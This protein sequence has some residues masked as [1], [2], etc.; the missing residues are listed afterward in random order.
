MTVAFSCLFFH[1]ANHAA[2]EIK[3]EA[4]SVEGIVIFSGDIPKRSIPDD[5]GVRRDLLQVDQKTHG[6]ESVVAWL[7]VV[8]AAR[9]SPMTNPAPP[10]IMDQ[11]GHE[12]VPR[13]IAV[14]SGQEVKFI[15][16][17]AA[18]HN[19]RT[20]SSVLA[21]EFNVFTGIEG[22]YKR[23]FVA[24]PRQRP[25]RVGCDIH[26]WMRGWVYVFD[27]P[28][29]AVTDSEG[30]FRIPSV[31]AGRYVLVIRQPDIRYASERTITVEAAKT[32]RVE[33]QLSAKDVRG[34]EVNP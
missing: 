6:V 31:P 26:P 34:D 12:F 17:D 28:Y 14:R 7:D 32:T 15:N 9:P 27:H 5:A 18:N 29:F 4:G 3:S 16:S 33:V 21:N 30:R 1:G 19:V 2:E 24:D 22:S 13:V 20:A 8:T 25:V 10:A 23:R 11:L